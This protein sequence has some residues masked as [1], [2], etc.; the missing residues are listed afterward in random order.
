MQKTRIGVIGVGT[1]GYRHAFNVAHKIPGAVL[2]AVCSRTESKARRVADELEAGRCFTSHR[3][4]LAAP[5]IEAVIIA[6]NTTAHPEHIRDALAAGKH[7]FCEKPLATDA[8]GCREVEKMVEAH[9]DRI[10]FPGFMRRYDDSYRYAKDL[11]RS[12]RLGR[13]Y[14]VL[15]HAADPV[16]SA[17]RLLA[18]A[19]SSGGLFLDLGVHDFDVAGW[20]LESRPR[21]AYAVGGCYVVKGF[22]EHGDIDNAAAIVHYENGAIASFFESRSAAHG[23]HIE[24]EVICEK[25]SVRIGIVPEK[26]RVFVA[27]SHSFG[28]MCHFDFLERFADAFVNEIQ[29]FV[30]CVQQGRQPENTVYD[31]TYATLAACA[32]RDSSAAGA[33]VPVRAEPR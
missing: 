13:P 23:L 5:D 1:L 11:V 15:C 4:L 31:S 9:P 20:F 24:T 28:R 18:I 29:A 21:T 3:D 6:S 14:A 17:D 27:D 12:G 16:I 33:V 22:A 7:V 8:A 26:N 2:A 25:G 10:F 30:D 32:A 19:G